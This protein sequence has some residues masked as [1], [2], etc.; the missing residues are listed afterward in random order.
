MFNL[1]SG[2]AVTLELLA[3][4][5]VAFSLELTTTALVTLPAAL[6]LTVNLKVLD[7][8]DPRVPTFQ[9][10]VSLSQP[11]SL[12]PVTTT[13]PD[14]DSATLTPVAVELPSLVT[15]IM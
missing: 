15:V 1:T 9:T 3:E 14:K 8:L 6:T 11:A 13:K 12:A 7:S 5:S 10:L 2:L 4:T